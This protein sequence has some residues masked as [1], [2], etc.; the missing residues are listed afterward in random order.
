MKFMTPMEKSEKLGPEIHFLGKLLGEVIREQAGLTLYELEEEIRLTARARREGQPGAEKAL[1][2][3]VHGLST[4]QARLIVRAFTVFFDLANLAEDRERVRVLRDRER[5]RH[6]EP[7]SESMEEAVLIMRRADFAPEKVQELID[8]LSIE[9]VFTA[10]PTEAKRR[11]VRGLVRRMRQ[12]LGQMDDPKLLPRDRDRLVALLCSSLTSLWQTE[13]VRPRRPS[14]SEEVEV[15]LSFASTLWEVVPRIYRDLRGALSRS[16]PEG[17]FRI[18]P[19]LRFGSW[20]GGD[21]DGNPNVTSDVTASTL[22]QMRKTAIEAHLGQCRRLFDVLTS[23]SLEA[24]VSGE[25]REALER[26]IRDYP[27]LAQLLEPI[28]EHEVYRRFLKSIEWRLERTGQAD[29]LTA[30]PPGSYCR[31]GELSADLGLIR[32][33]L[34]ANGGERVIEAELQDWL[35]QTEIFGLH[36]AR[37]DIR[38]ESAWNLRV[39]T[40]ILASAQI[41]SDYGSLSEEKRQDVLRSSVRHAGAVSTA[42]LSDETQETVRLFSVLAL[43]AANIGTEALGG[44]IISMTHALSDVLAVLWLCQC[45]SL[46]GNAGDDGLDIDI[47]PLFETIRDLENAPRILTDM[48]SDP[49]YREHL[50]RRE[51]TQ[52]VMIGY[53]DS[54][55]DGGYLAACWALYEAQSTLHSVAQSQGVRVIFFH[56]RGGSLGRGG[57]P[58]ARSILSLPRESLTAGLRMT[59]QGEV[60]ADRY[61]DPHIAGRHLE[62]VVWAT[63]MSSTQP[64]S[65]PR[66]RWREAM[67]EMSAVSLQHYRA[68]IEEPGFLTYFEQSTPIGEIEAL[69]IASRPAHRRGGRSLSDLRSIPWVFAW[70]QSRCLIPAWYGI[71]AAFSS[72]ADHHADGWETLREM[73]GAWSFFRATIDNAALALAKADQGIARLYSDLV[74]APAI[75]DRI[76]QRVATEYALAKESVLRTQGQAELLGE[77]PWLRRSITVRNPN[78]DPLNLIQVEWLRRLR[79]CE[80]TGDA[81]CEAACRDLLRLT[82]EGVATGMRT[83]G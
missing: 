47:V 5:R 15:G 8:L 22:L 56:G 21:R 59:E 37:L 35:W 55:K 14:V 26:R 46:C 25:I 19:F 52:I 31:S 12:T 80:G 2:A 69:P 27:E 61:D 17:S 83:T 29:S 43:A 33:S 9:L 76:W 78:T 32:D 49:V 75:R 7:R 71:G 67:A 62:Q 3:N 30:T 79:E 82:I 6:P 20:I 4:A 74:D 23:S 40:E 73:Y 60:L 41:A 58:A 77:I 64:L 54:T 51:N 70:T 24:P 28:S 68:L 66:P 13:L 65:P 39:M 42:G 34:F 81:E 44:Y 57:G 36:I 48:L 45:R 50:S 10:H 72:F 53:S 1:L 11:S 63:L 16:Y 18:P 38:Q